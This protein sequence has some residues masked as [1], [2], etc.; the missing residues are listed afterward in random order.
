VS[1]VG[2]LDVTLGDISTV[3]SVSFCPYPGAEQLL[4]C[5]ADHKGKLIFLCVNTTGARV[6]VDRMHELE[7]IDEITCISWSPET[8]CI[9]SQASI[10]IAVSLFNS[11]QVH[12]ITA[13]FRHGAM[14]PNAADDEESI[15]DKASEPWGEV[16]VLERRACEAPLDDKTKRAW[17]N[18]IAFEPSAGEYL[19]AVGDDKLCVV[20]ESRELSRVA[21]FTLSSPGQNVRWCPSD[22]NRLVVGEKCGI[23]RM[24]DLVNKMPIMTFSSLSSGPLTCID[25]CR[26]NEL[27]LSACIG[28]ETLFWQTSMSGLPVDRLP[29]HHKGS[30]QLALFN[31][32]LF[33]TRSRPR[34]QITVYNRRLNQM[35]M[36]EQLNAG[37]GLS[38]HAK[39]PVLAAGGYGKLILFQLN[40]Y[41]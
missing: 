8:S 12:V 21:L 20:W 2:R 38:W 11:K 7:L 16:E 26:S 5:G 18:D 37:N 10:K 27:L 24:Y 23:I 28:S 34:S 35:L 29:S 1:P 22:S 30:E 41:T 39:Q 33:A 14:L 25:W 40:A 19:A 36:E 15:A 13:R 3:N 32:N 4:V 9:G 31:A 17:I 6:E